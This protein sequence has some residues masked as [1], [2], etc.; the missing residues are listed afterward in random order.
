MWYSKTCVK[1]PLKNRQNK[2]LNDKRL[3]E[4]QKYCRTLLWSILQYFLPALSDNWSWKPIFG[5][6]E[7]G[8]FTQVLLYVPRSCVLAHI[9][10]FGFLNCLKS[11][12]THS[13]IPE[14]VSLPI[15]LTLL[16][17]QYFLYG[18]SKLIFFKQKCNIFSNSAQYIGCGYSLE[19]SHFYSNEYQQPLFWAEIWKKCWGRVVDHTG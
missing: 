6:F 11:F 15:M 13:F 3:N 16:Y 8:R 12:C 19:A 10:L 18:Y 1:R 2:D 7:S 5:L 9:T 4:G 17:A 14:N